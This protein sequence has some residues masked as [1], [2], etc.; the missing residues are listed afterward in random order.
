MTGNFRTALWAAAIWY[1]FAALAH[2]Q[3]PADLPRTSA[4]IY[5]QVTDAAGLPVPGASV[6]LR[7]IVTGLSEHRRTDDA[8]RYSFDG[9][10]PGSYWLVASRPGL[11]DQGRLVEVAGADVLRDVNFSLPVA[12]LIQ[13]VT[14]VSSSRVEELQEESP[15]KVEAVTREQMRDTGYERVSDVLA[16]IPGVVTR[17]GSRASAAVAGEQIQGIDSR[18][19][20]VLMDGLPIVGARGIKSGVMNLSRQSVSR[21]ERVEVVKGAASSLYG[22][23]AIG[24]VI[25]MITRE[26]SNPFEM[27]LN[28]SGGSLSALDARADFGTQVKNLSAFLDLERH[29]QQ[30]YALIPDSPTTVGPRYRRNDLLF[31]TRYTLNPR[32]ALG[33]T[34]NAYHNNDLGSALGETGLTR[35]TSNDSN[36]NYG[37]TGDFVLAPSTLLQVRGYSARYDEN[38]QMNP[39]TGQPAPPDLANLNERYRRLDATLGHHLGARQFVQLGGEWVQDLY[40]GANRLVGDNAGQQVTTTDGWFQDRIQLFRRATLTVGGRY[41][42]HSRFGGYFVPKAGLVVRAAEH[43][44]LRA[45][46]GHGFRAP[47]LGQLYFRFANPAS[48]YQVIGNPNLQPEASRSYSAG[49]VYTRSRFRLGLNLYRNDVRDLIEPLLVGTPRTT[50]ELKA[51]EGR[52]GIPSTFNPLL[53]RMLFIYANLG[54][55][56][57]RGFEVDGDASLGRG[58]RVRGAYTFLDARDKVSGAPLTQRHRHQG[59]LAGEYFHRRWGLL[60]NVRGS[61]FSSYLL[62]AQTRSRAYPYRLW[63]LSASKRLAGGCSIY[64]TI[65]N[66]FDSTDRK[67]RQPTPTFDRPDYG[68]TFRIGLRYSFARKRN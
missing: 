57:T 4:T 17:G 34:A 67:L 36:Q 40:R 1:C 3:A 24:G 9:L 8:G 56:Y 11:S 38:S 64:G 55:I 39:L 27:N 30:A 10:R 58:F 32:A 61:L 21:L 51:I 12:G 42:N 5:G 28:L 62:N 7:K 6:T 18:Q 13:Q 43:L 45:S 26:P 48:F 31:K 49:A 68:R 15:V 59:F 14:V 33:F 35:I 54:R 46:Y 50:A 53:G 29:Q 47:D 23:D 2:G 60:A 52:Y 37:L 19:V 44:T 16:E 20:L 22:S 25:N 65:D 66:L 63:G 41:Q